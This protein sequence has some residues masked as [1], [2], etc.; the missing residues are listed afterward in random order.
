M[1]PLLSQPVWQLNQGLLID[2]MP[3]LEPATAMLAAQLQKASIPATADVTAG[4]L[5]LHLKSGH[6]VH[7]FMSPHKYL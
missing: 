6:G 7:E 3:S 1:H 4:L 5:E 2:M